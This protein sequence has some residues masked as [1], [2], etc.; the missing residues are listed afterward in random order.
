M[1]P[2][3]P[4]RRALTVKDVMSIQRFAGNS[5]VAAMLGAHTVV[6]REIVGEG[7]ASENQLAETGAPTIQPGPAAEAETG[8][9]QAATNA[10][11]EMDGKVDSGVRTHAFS[12]AGKTGT[13]KW[14]HAGG[15]NGGTGYSPASPTLVGPAYDTAVAPPGGSA[16]AWIRKDTGTAKVNTWYI[17][18]PQGNNGAAKWDG[19]GTLVHIN[20]KA[21][22]RMDT[23]EVGHSN[24]SKRIHDQHIKPLETRV[25]AY[26]QQFSGADAPKKMTGATETAA[27]DALQAHIDWNKSIN[28]FNTDDLAANTPMG[29]WDTTDQAKADFYFDAGAKKIAGVDYGHAIE[30]P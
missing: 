3:A 17:G 16:T 21:V 4:S 19:S 8:N 23:H 13:A 10:F 5:A 20:A 28:D 7:K 18:V 9:P 30:A 6:Q 25:A 14:H 26:R 2:A 12:S 29:T 22:G 24:E 11:G 27:K 1:I 15:P